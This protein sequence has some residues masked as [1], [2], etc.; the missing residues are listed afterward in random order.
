MKYLILYS[1][2][3]SFLF[4]Q[5]IDVYDR[6]FQ[7]QPDFDIDVLHYDINLNLYDHIKS[8]NGK[9]S[10]KFKVLKPKLNFIKLNIE[11]VKVI[12]VYEK[13]RK[14]PF[15][16]KNGLLRINP[17]RSI[18]K[19]E[20]LTY[21]IFYD[22][23]GKVSDPTK[24]GM[25]VLLGLGFFDKSEDNPN[26]AQTH[27]FPTGARHWFPS[28]DHPADKATSRIAATVRSD[29]KVLANGLLTE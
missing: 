22:S 9:T 28:N 23:E 21:T 24:F 18:S 29:W 6:P 3:F 2:I 19:N 11:T 15:T 7:T 1:T 17:K 8:F 10:V 13:N 4:S 27:S 16:Q 14:L 5:K 25:N 20:V 26:L 12:S